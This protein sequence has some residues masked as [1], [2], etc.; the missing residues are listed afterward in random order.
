[1][2]QYLFDFLAKD[3]CCTCNHFAI[4][5]NGTKPAN[6]GN[7]LINS[8]KFL[9]HMNF[10]FRFLSF[11]NVYFMSHVHISWRTTSPDKKTSS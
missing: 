7:T 1:M 5:W 8:D 4:I 9:I 3:Y 2:A 6:Y 11:Q 10:V